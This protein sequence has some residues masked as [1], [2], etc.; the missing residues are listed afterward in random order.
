MG[1]S[2]AF[3]KV[4]PPNAFGGGPA[5]GARR[6]L[7]PE[8]TDDLGK[9]RETKF[10][11]MLQVHE[12]LFCEFL[13]HKYRSLHPDIREF[14]HCIKQ[15]CNRVKASVHGASLKGA[16]ITRPSTSASKYFHK[17]SSGAL[18]VKQTAVLTDN[19]IHSIQHCQVY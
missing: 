6:C 14:I 4:V 15:S 10:Q 16:I 9:R 11:S 17:C 13:R 7:V 8:R 19:N 18:W 5:A 1:F 12:I 2:L 3:G